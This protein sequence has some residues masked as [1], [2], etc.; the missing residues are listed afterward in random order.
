MEQKPQTIGPWPTG[1]NNRAPAFSLP[2]D[3][4]GRVTALR[5]AVNADIQMTGHVK[6]RAGYERIYD[7]LNTHSGYACEVGTFFVE[8][9]YLKKLNDDDTATLIVGGITGPV[10]YECFNSIVYYSDGVITGRIVN[11]VATSW[12]VDTQHAL[13]ADYMAM[14]ACRIL[15]QKNGRIYGAVG[16]IV[17]YTD[18]Y[19]LGSVHRQRNFYQFTDDVTILEP[20]N[21]GLW[22]VADKTYFYSDDG[23]V[24]TALEY[25]AIYGTSRRIPNSNDVMWYSKKGAVMAAENGQIKNVQEQNVAVDSG[26]DGVSIIREE[27]GNRRFIATI[28]NPAVSPM[29]A[30]D[31]MEMEV[32]RKG[33]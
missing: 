23:G 12:P 30:R 32:V 19:T 7:A 14:P 26:T 4:D 31:W 11:S 25:G 10:C 5:N 9:M 3:Q 15:R 24:L 21:G 1:I 20:V 17:W 29:A 27:D 8:G 18:P 28:N 6:R 13:D 33:T 22:I 16:K 2:R